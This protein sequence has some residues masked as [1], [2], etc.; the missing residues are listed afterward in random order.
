[1]KLTIVG[2]D[3]AKNVMQMHWVDPDTGEVVNK[4]C[5]RH[6]RFG[7][8]PGRAGDRQCDAFDHGG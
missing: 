7:G 2:V 4:R 5:D 3:I 1:M 6:V 8:F